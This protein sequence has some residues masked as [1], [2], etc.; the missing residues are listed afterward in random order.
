MFP[1]HPPGRN[2][3]VILGKDLTGVDEILTPL[4]ND[5]NR[6]QTILLEGFWE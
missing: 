5:L 1:S 2:I 3:V 6:T 4:K